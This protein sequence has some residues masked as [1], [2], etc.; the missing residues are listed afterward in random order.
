MIKSK[1]EV[2]L[3]IF[4]FFPDTC[5]CHNWEALGTPSALSLSLLKILSQFLKSVIRLSLPPSKDISICSSYIPSRLEES[6]LRTISRY[7]WKDDTVVGARGSQIPCQARVLARTVKYTDFHT[8]T[9]KNSLTAL[10]AS[11]PDQVTAV[12]LGLLS[13]HV[14]L[15]GSPV[16]Y[17]EFALKCSF[18]AH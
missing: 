1:L 12:P 4:P 15:F 17:S 8:S 5:L 10:T 6:L 18:A 11:H 9:M 14:N 7:Q 3:A 16:T 13:R 2:L